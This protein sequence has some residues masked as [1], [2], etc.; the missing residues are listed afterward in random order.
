MKPQFLSITLLLIA[1]SLLAL[2]CCIPVVTAAGDSVTA[3]YQNAFSS[4]PK[5]ETK[6]PNYYY[7]DSGLQVYHFSIEP[8]SGCYAYT[9]ISTYEKGPFSLEYDV[10]LNKINEGTTF[11]LGFSGKDMD[12]EKG[13]NVLT[14]FTNA[15]F[16]QIMWLHLVTPGNK[17]VEINSESGDTQTSGDKAYKGPTAHYELNKTYHITVNYNEDQRIL[18]MTVNEKTSGKEIW[19]YYLNTLEDLS[20]MNR[21]YLGAIGDYGMMNRYATGYIDNVRLTVPTVETVVST[22]PSTVATTTAPLTA[23]T[24]TKKKTPAPASTPSETGIPV[25]T[26]E[27][28]L[29]D[30]IP[31]FA[32]CAGGLCCLY[33]PG[34]RA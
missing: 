15:K 4:D 31:V 9:P 1:V 10:T 14:E 17:M 23:P 7:W 5:W 32:V 29:S 6:C 11:R 20:G 25:T 28:P 26:Q 8:S 13:P 18:I 19:S 21:L 3:L 30:V 2:A 27:S 12:P 22:A 24:A 16:G 34:K 33:L